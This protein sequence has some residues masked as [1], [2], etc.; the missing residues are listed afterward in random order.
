MGIPN[1]HTTIDYGK[2]IQ[3]QSQEVSERISPVKTTQQ[4]K[5]KQKSLRNANL[6]MKR[7]R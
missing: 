6:S 5:V 1:M 2:L 7:K 4:G 3:Q